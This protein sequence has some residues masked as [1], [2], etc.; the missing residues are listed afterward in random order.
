MTGEQPVRIRVSNT[1]SGDAR[2]SITVASDGKEYL[3]AT[4]SSPADELQEITIPIPPGQ[5]YTLDVDVSASLDS[6][7]AVTLGRDTVRASGSSLSTTDD[8]RFTHSGP[9]TL[10]VVIGGESFLNIES[11]G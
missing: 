6:P 4:L 7:D 9:S 10:R 1:L 3:A 8:H 11:D 2:A 5:T